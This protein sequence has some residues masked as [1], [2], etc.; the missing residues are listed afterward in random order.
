MTQQMN[1]HHC[2]GHQY[3]GPAWSAWRPPPAGVIRL[4][5]DRS[6]HCVR[7]HHEKGHRVWPVCRNHSAELY[8]GTRVWIQLAG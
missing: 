8:R 3:N 2:V 7:F 5:W 4:W 1:V 6:V